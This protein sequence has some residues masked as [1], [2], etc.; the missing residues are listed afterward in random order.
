VAG[1][2]AA[3]EVSKEPQTNEESGEMATDESA[4]GAFICDCGKSFRRFVNF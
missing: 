3:S 2:K 1:K 4:E